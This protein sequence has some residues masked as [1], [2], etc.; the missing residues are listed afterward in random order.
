VESVNFIAV[1]FPP[2]LVD[3][4]RFDVALYPCIFCLPRE[5][6]SSRAVNG[7]DKL[8]VHLRGCVPNDIIMRG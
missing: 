6:S 5:T 8:S 4:A 3:L 2:I 1:W 7:E